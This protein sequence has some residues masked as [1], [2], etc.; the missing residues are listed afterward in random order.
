MRGEL[1]RRLPSNPSLNMERSH[2]LQAVSRAVPE[3]LRDLE[4]LRSLHRRT[5]LQIGLIYRWD[6][7]HGPQGASLRK[8]VKQW[9]NKY[10]LPDEWC[11]DA[12]VVYLGSGKPNTGLQPVP[13][14]RNR[15]E[16]TNDFYY[17]HPGWCPDDAISLNVHMRVL[18]RAIKAHLT[19][20]EAEC[21]RAREDWKQA[22]YVVSRKRSRKEKPSD[23]HF[24][25]TARFQCAGESYTEIADT[26][27]FMDD[28]TIRR[29]VQETAE[30]IGLT[31]RASSGQH[32]SRRQ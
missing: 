25:W 21:R 19:R 17:F 8:R 4:K 10:N 7:L 14:A 6:S 12:A 20:Y 26:E 18:R 32:S 15:T 13:Y 28:S 23:R 2:F 22:G 11:L 1:Q 31:L 27:D 29:A 5:A 9:A 3:S 30:R 24:L 16:W